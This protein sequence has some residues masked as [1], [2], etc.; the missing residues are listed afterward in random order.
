MVYLQ[1]FPVEVRPVTRHRI[2]FMVHVWKMRRK[3]WCN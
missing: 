2:A 3:A 1:P